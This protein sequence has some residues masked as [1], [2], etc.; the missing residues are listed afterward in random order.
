MNPLLFAD[1]FRHWKHRVIL[2]SRKP[3]VDCP[4][5]VIN[6]LF[7]EM[8]YK[9]LGGLI[10]THGHDIR[11]HIARFGLYSHV[12]LVEEKSPRIPNTGER[13]C[14]N[15]ATSLGPFSSEA[16]FRFSRHEATYLASL[17]EAQARDDS[18]PSTI[19]SHGQL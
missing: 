16:N 18:R 6:R 1:V 11:A 7:E 15:F 5:W 17:L 2:P 12:S 10:C 19:Q 9:L 13:H 8:I 14:G 4:I 3:T